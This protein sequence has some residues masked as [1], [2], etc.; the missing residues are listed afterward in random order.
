MDAF[1][2]LPKISVG[3]KVRYANEPIFALNLRELIALAFVPANDIPD[4]FS[5]LCDTAFWQANDDD[6]DSPKLEEI[7]N[8]FESTYIGINTRTQGRRRNAIFTP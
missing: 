1:F 3:L 8:Y 5:Q 7:L 2:T 6:E 4:A